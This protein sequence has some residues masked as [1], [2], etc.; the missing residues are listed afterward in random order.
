MDNIPEA[1]FATLLE[2][3]NHIAGAIDDIRPDI[4]KIQAINKDM[5]Y[6]A[7]KTA[8]L[9]TLTDMSRFFYARSV[10]ARQTPIA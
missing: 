5:E 3:V 10:Y 6:L 9:S 8:H 7:D 4:K 2:R 1:Q